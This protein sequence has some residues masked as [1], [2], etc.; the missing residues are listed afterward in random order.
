MKNSKFGS[1]KSAV[2]VAPSKLPVMFPVDPAKL[3]VPPITVPVCVALKL[4]VVLE[5]HVSSVSNAQIVES[6]QSVSTGIST[7]IDAND[8]GLPATL[9]T[10]TFVSK[11]FGINQ[12]SN[13]NEIVDA[14]QGCTT[15][16]GE[17]G[18]K[19]VLVGTGNLP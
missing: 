9:F 10:G 2:N 6:L 11:K 7:N 19:F 12:F 13:L 4:G 18:S 8:D 3:P 16:G 14:G 17:A 5:K 1:V 15:S